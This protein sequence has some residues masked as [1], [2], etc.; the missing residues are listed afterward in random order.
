LEIG[1]PES[2][3]TISGPAVLRFG[4]RGESLGTVIDP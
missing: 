4:E 1:P 3:T 2:G